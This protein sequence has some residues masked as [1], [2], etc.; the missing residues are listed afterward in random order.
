MPTEP[1]E[2]KRWPL[3]VQFLFIA[4]VIPA[5]F[6]LR[7]GSVGGFALGLT[8]FLLILG[9]I[10]EFVPRKGDALAA[11]TAVKITPGRY[12]SLGVVWAF[13]IPFAPFLSW[14]LT[15]AFDVDA[16]NW[17]ALLGI[18]ATLCVV[19]PLVTVLP[20]VRYVRRGTAGVSI[21]VLVVGTGF[22]VATGAGS[23]FDV[24][25]GPSWQDVTITQL[26]DSDFKLQGREVR[27]PDAVVKLS[28]GRS[29]SRSADVAV[30]EGRT[31]LL[32]LRGFGRI[33]DAVP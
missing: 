7:F 14:V 27:A 13:S 5:V 26:D 20:L 11:E 25:A 33:I 9:A 10:I 18:R 24:I 3:P 21:A 19:L 12:D 29:L 2:S 31:R 22:P 30:H 1:A 15:N 8:A 6:W 32:I 23:A 4:V 28:D 16:S 17:R